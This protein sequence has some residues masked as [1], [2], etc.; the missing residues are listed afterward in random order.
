MFPPQPRTSV[1]P[2]GKL[3]T[4]AEKGAM[5]GDC[6]ARYKLLNQHRAELLAKYPDQW[7]ALGD[8]WV[9][10]AAETRQGVREKLVECGA[11]TQYSA[12]VRLETN[13]PHRIPG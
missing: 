12:I 13:P 8:N 1:A 7:V 11:Y 10:V 6:T 4:L 2:Q 9:F 5:N 3:T